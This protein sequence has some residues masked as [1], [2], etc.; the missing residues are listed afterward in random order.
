M[1]ALSNLS[2]VLVVLSCSG[3]NTDLTPRPFHT[4]NLA[5]LPH[6]I[7]VAN[8][9]VLSGTSTLYHAL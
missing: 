8:N 4:A 1:L 3:H 9:N 7:I 6:V 2:C 5:F